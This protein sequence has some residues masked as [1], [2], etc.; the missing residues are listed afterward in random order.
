MKKVIIGLTLLIFL[1]PSACKKG[2][3]AGSAE[4]ALAKKYAKYKVAVYKDMGLKT[5]LAT[6][7]KAE[8]V[9]LLAEEKNTDSKGKSID[10]YK[11]QLADDSIGYIE[12]K[13]LADVPVVF[14][15]ETKAFVRPTI[16]SQIYAL[17]P[18]GELGFIVGEKAQWVQIYVGKVNNKNI[19]EQW[20]NSG[21]SKEEKLVLDAKQYAAAIEALAG[22]DEEK[23]NLARETLQTLL[24]GNTVISDM[25]RAKL[26]EMGIIQSGQENTAESAGNSGD[27]PSDDTI[28]N[29]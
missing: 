18:K 17:I 26:I 4:S 5:W 29:E 11:V 9:N 28:S 2:E 16:G 7:E 10:L 20:V 21:F 8:D 6:L 15:E 19:T 1:T 13:H 12:P 14:I 22:S 23:K 3:N 24:N 27:V 25:A